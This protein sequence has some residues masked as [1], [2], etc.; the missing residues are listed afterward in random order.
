MK[1]SW[2]LWW[3]LSIIEVLSFLVFSALLWMRDVDAT[4]AVQTTELKWINIGILFSAYVLPFGIQ[5]VWLI[6]NVVLNSKKKA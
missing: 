5:I 1:I 4:G 3:I 6:I 2:V